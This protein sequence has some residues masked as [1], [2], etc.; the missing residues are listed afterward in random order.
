M[1]YIDQVFLKKYYCVRKGNREKEKESVKENEVE[2][3][4]YIFHL[5]SFTKF[6]FENYPKF[7]KS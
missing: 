5:L 3:R 6:I 2:E 4:K 1:S 7:Q